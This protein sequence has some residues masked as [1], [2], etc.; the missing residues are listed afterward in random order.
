MHWLSIGSAFFYSHYLYV[1][2]IIQIER[3]FYQ[4]G[5]RPLLKTAT[6]IG[7]WILYYFTLLTYYSTPTAS[8]ALQLYALIFNLFWI[9]I[10]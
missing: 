3:K 1:D 7:N 8:K 5:L 4:N 6:I 9:E 2:E 10:K